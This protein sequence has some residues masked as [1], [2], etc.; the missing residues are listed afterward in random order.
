[1]LLI[2]VIC[3]SIFASLSCLKMYRCIINLSNR[4]IRAT[5]R[6]SIDILLICRRI[7]I[8]FLTFILCSSKTYSI[9]ILFD[10]INELKIYFRISSYFVLSS[11]L[12]EWRLC[13]GIF[14]SIKNFSVTRSNMSIWS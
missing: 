11:F 2:I 8:Y 4:N 9:H 10:F 7:F 14:K 1:M 12:Y 3:D 6:L 5:S 13:V